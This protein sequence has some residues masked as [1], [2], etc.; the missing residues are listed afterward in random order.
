LEHVSFALGAAESLTI[1]ND[2][3][4]GSKH[5]QLLDSVDWFSVG[6]Q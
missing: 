2:S 6:Q 3:V 1:I 5:Q 4:M